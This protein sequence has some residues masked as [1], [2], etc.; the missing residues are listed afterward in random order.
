MAGTSSASRVL[1]A[2]YSGAAAGLRQP[3]FMNRVRSAERSHPSSGSDSL[4]KGWATLTTFSTQ[5]LSG[6][7]PPVS[8]WLRKFSSRPRM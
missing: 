2:K 8:A 1:D 3:A 7:S 4:L 5:P 6:S